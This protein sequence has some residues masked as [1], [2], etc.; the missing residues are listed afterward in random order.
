MFWERGERETR[1]RGER[2]WRLRLSF[3]CY[4]LFSAVVVVVVVVV[5]VAVD[6]GNRLPASPAPSQ[7]Y[8][9]HARSKEID[10]PHLLVHARHGRNSSRGS[11]VFD[12]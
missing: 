2:G 9:S 1:E 12:R 5:V 3:F 4:L 6:V 8:N 11:G 10:I 7:S